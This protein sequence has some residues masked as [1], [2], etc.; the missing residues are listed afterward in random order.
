MK[1]RI[2]F[3]VLL[4]AAAFFAGRYMTE[5]KVESPDA[6]S[7]NGLGDGRDVIRKSFPLGP[8]ARVEVRGINGSVEVNTA[9]TDT[10]DVQV[11]RT[12]DSA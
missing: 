5:T 1:R 8:G 4:V 10:A 9:E 3:A 11:T 12:G 7:R 6:A 2:F